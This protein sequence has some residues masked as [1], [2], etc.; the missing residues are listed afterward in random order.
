MSGTRLVVAMPAFRRL[1]LARTISS[2]GNGMAPIALAFGVLALPGATPT[3]LSIVLAAQAI[4]VIL[5]LPFGGVIADRVGSARMIWST[6]VILSAFVMATAVLL[7]TGHATVPI[8]A[9]IG[10]ISGVLNALW[11]PAYAGLVPDTVKDDDRLQPANALI[12]VGTNAGYII[13]TAIAGILVAAWGAGQAIA[14]DALTFLAAGVLVFTI[15]STAMRRESGESMLGDLVHGWKVFI[16]YRWVVI[17]VGAWSFI[18]MA[19]RGGEEVMGPALAL[20]R[21]DGPR[22]WSIVMAAQA[23]GLLVGALV[24]TRVH[25]R[26]P[27]FAVSLASIA[28]PL[29]FLSLGMAWPLVVVVPLSFL[30]GL[31]FEQMNVVWMTAMQANIP[32]ESL[33]R[34]SSYDQAGSLMFGPIGIALAGPSVVWIG[35]RE[36]L[37]LA[38][39]IAL[40]GVLAPLLS[41]SV[42]ELSSASTTPAPPLG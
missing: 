4:P 13:G 29:W 12:G 28:L 24:A 21:Y 27:L 23:V 5:L 16:S 9:V 11:F 1:L 2:I 33:S 6:D 17:V 37:L 8:L 18:V 14:I 7:I 36:G 15:R 20:E 38:A 31:A 41:R 19:W 26:R 30:W 34:V 42:R 32:R 40:L 25:W 3:S 22:G 10:V 39:L 35:L